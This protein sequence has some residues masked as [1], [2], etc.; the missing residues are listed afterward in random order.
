MTLPELKLPDQVTEAPQWALLTAAAVSTVLA[1]VMMYSRTRRTRALTMAQPTGRAKEVRQTVAAAGPLAVLGACGMV[2]SLYGLYG[3]ATQNMQLAWFWAIPVMAIFDMAEVTC[4]VSLYRS[5]TVEAAWTRPMR[6]TRRMAW[7]LVAASAAMNAAHAPGNW[8]AT[9]VF[10]A[11]PAISAK[12]IEFELDKQMAAN[13]DQESDGGGPGLVRLVQLAYIH[14][15]ANIFARLGFDGASKD[16]LIHQDARIRRAARQIHELRRALDERDTAT[17]RRLNRA[18][19]SVEEKQAKAELAIDVAG[20]AGDTAGQLTLARNLVTRGRVVDLARMDVRDPMGIVT[21]LEELAIVPSAEAI[22]AGARAAQAEKQRQEAEAARDEARAAQKA[23]EAEAAKVREE[24]AGVLKAAKKARA[25]AEEAAA[26]ALRKAEAASARATQAEAARAAA[27]EERSKI[28]T[29]VEELSTRA[30]T[31]RTSTTASDG[32]RQKLAARLAELR[33]QVQEATD[34]VSQRRKEAEAARGEAQRAID[35]RHAAAREVE[36]A[37][38]AVEKLQEQ[39]RHLQER[40]EQYAQQRAELAT[41]IDRLAAERA[42]AEED[43]RRAHEAAEK[44]R[45]AAEAEE[46]AR[47]AASVALRHARTELLD[48]LTSPDAYEPPRWT[49]PAKVRGWELY[50][51]KVRTEGIEPTDAELAGEDR[52]PS[53]ARKWL[54]EFRAELAKLTTAALP[55]Q[56]GAHDRTADEAPVLV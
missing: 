56:Q 42:E 52:D 43:A 35:T 39:V 7:A 47:R 30:Q 14:A 15:W 33:D 41:T 19:K 22:K 8:M 45:K 13:S 20:I 27:E 37:Q 49:S 18:R 40:A 55:S 34:L 38:E 28:A 10:A 4:F 31:L 32:E 9:L 12:L 5:A 25:E 23:A 46:G 26:E 21:T 6:R 53:T 29:D 1:L 44:A 54:P 3:F 36:A 48:A 2:L 17:G 11:V 16:G 50:M 51:H 24:A